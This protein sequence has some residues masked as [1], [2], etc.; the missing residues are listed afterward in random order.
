MSVVAIGGSDG[1][2]GVSSGRG[3]IQRQLL[4]RT[5]AVVVATSPAAD[6]TTDIVVVL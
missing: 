4:S 1:G 5:W 6:P 3:W 2:G